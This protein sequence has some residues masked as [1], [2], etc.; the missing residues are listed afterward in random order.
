MLVVAAVLTVLSTRMALG[1]R[2]AAILDALL[3]SGAQ[4]RAAKATASR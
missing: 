2:I 1:E 4:Q 3:A